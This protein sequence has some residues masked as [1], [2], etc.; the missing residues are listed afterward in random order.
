MPWKIEL[1]SYISLHWIFSKRIF[2]FFSPKYSPCFLEAASFIILQI[3]VWLTPDREVHRDSLRWEIL[4]MLVQMLLRAEVTFIILWIYKHVKFPLLDYLCMISWSSIPMLCQNRKV[5]VMA[6]VAS[7]RTC[8]WRSHFL[9]L[10]GLKL[11]FWC[12]WTIY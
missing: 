11:F 1:Y 12:S 9:K 6:Y 3:L 10:N 8:L 5:V 2:Y 7:G 4:K